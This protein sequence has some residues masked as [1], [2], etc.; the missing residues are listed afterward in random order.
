MFFI[1][2]LIYIYKNVFHI[3]SKLKFNYAKRLGSGP[4]SKYY[5]FGST[6]NV[7]AITRYVTCGAD[8]GRW[9]WWLVCRPACRSHAGRAPSLGSAAGRGDGRQGQSGPGYPRLICTTKLLHLW[10]ICKIILANLSGEKYL[11]I[12]PNGSKKCKIHFS[13]LFWVWGDRRRPF[14]G[15]NC[16]RTNTPRQLL[17]LNTY[18]Q[19]I[20]LTFLTI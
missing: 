8:C 14:L 9:R 11:I 17:N 6:N 2:K 12:F 1:E 18:V 5:T 16:W 3:F 4:K 20:Y 15:S 19:L 10:N 13:P 7:S